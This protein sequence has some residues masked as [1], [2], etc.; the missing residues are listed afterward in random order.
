V[1]CDMYAC[2][3]DRAAQVACEMYACATDRAA[4]S[5][6]R[7]APCYMYVIYV[8]LCC[9]GGNPQNYRQLVLTGMADMHL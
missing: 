2:A 6:S 1:A 4:H 8:V 5:L 7:P 3:T 9:A